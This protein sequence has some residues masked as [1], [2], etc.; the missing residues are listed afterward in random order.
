MKIA[1][2]ALLGLASCVNIP[3]NQLVRINTSA[4]ADSD[5]LA[6]SKG[7]DDKAEGSDSDDDDDDDDDEDGDELVQL[8]DPCVYLDETQDELDYQVDMFSRTL[9]VRHW[10]NAQNIAKAMGKNGTSAPGLKIHTWELYNNAFSF[11]RVR[12]YGF[13]NDNMDMLEH[14]QD[15][16]NLNSSN[17]VNFD[18]FL[19]TAHQVQS[20]LNTKYHNGE[21]TDPAT[22]DPKAKKDE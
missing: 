2:L 17:S 21:F 4:Y 9:D 20:N 12:R 19:R 8:Q 3:D 10:T 6:K 14:F 11:P 15:N 5:A 7:D 16:V 1:I 18:N 22:F 13:V